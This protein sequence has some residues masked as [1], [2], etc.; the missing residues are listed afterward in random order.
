MSLSD[1]VIIADIV[2]YGAL[3]LGMVLAVRRIRRAQINPTDAFSSLD[4]AL[5]KRFPEIAPGFTFREGVGRARILGLEVNWESV[6]RALTQYE[7]YR[8]GEGPIPTDGSAEVARLAG[9][10]MKGGRFGFGT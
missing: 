1:Y 5:N 2:V 10:L 3:V 7:A 6:D 9:I 8:Y 4:L